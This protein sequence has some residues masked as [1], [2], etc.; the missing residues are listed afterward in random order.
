MA[1][2]SPSG[3]PASRASVR[4]AR[5]RQQPALDEI[6]AKQALDQSVGHRRVA[7]L[8]RPGDQQVRGER[9]RLPYDSV[10]S[11]AMPTPAPAARTRA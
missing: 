9:V 8:L 3:S 5:Y 7:T 1:R 2:T 10:E 11:K 6:R 4:A